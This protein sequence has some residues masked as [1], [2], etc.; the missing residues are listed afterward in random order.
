[1]DARARTRFLGLALVLGVLAGWLVAPQGAAVTEAATPA[2]HGGIDL[3]R[4]GVFTTQATWLWCTAA[5]IQI[6]RNIV[7]HGT[8]HAASRQRAYFD[9]MR[10]HNRY[11]LPL[12]A[13][14]DAAGWAAGFRHFVDD[15]YQLVASR[16][17]DSALRLAVTRLRQTNLPVGI[18]VDHGNHAWLLTGFTATAD[19]LTTSRFT[20]TSVRVTG[21][22]YGLQ[23]RNGY[24]MPPDTRLTPAQLSGF[25]TPWSYPPVPMAWGG[26]F[27]SIQPVPVAAA[28]PPAGPSP[29]ASTTPPTA[30]PMASPSPTA[31]S[32]TTPTPVPTVNLTA[33][34]TA[35][36]SE[37]A[38][39]S[40]A[41]PGD[42]LPVLVLAI[43]GVLAAIAMAIAYRT[44][45]GRRGA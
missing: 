7:L 40:P 30:V 38:P 18:T 11:V 16:T 35:M 24:D 5:D 13:G 23:S 20:I 9:W 3:Y 42:A 21:P 45:R 41:T 1:M 36:P 33:P 27:V 2:W 37:P 10:A 43:I 19:P 15:R 8:E 28:Q 29:S 12:S 31:S 25:F 14:V 17:F 44:R 39:R 32:T 22:L 4:S 34:P 6:A 26:R